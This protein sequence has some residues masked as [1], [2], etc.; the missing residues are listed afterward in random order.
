MGGGI[1]CSEA[2][3]LLAAP[4]RRS[5]P[6]DPR[7]APDLVCCEPRGWPSSSE[8]GLALGHGDLIARISQPP[9]QD[10][11]AAPAAAGLDLDGLVVL[12]GRRP[13]ARLVHL[14]KKGKAAHSSGPPPVAKEPVPCLRALDVQKDAKTLLWTVQTLDWTIHTQDR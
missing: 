3:L 4:R 8:R 2:R 7:A 10:K 14:R 5:E 13:A 12:H 1:P 6:S 11:A 9:V